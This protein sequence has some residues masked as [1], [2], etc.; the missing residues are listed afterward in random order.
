MNMEKQV[1][2]EE[3]MELYKE[4]SM[5]AF[6]ILYNRH[7]AKVYGYLGKRVKSRFDRDEIHQNIFLKLHRSRRRYNSSFPFLPW[8]FTICRS[9]LIDYMR[10]KEVKE[11]KMVQDEGIIGEFAPVEPQPS[12]PSILAPA[13]SELNNDQREAIQMRYGK[14][15]SFEEIARELNTSVP[16]ARQVISR[17][18]RKLRSLMNNKEQE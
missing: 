3:L 4:G 8:L 16:N 15:F 10:A 7:S 1:T 12:G 5:E 9:V 11:R 2:D 18:L 14:D 6:E 17:S 13:L